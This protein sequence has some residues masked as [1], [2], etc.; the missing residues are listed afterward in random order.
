MQNTNIL[1]HR[2]GDHIFVMNENGEV[3]AWEIERD[4]HLNPVDAAEAVSS[5]ST[6]QRAEIARAQVMW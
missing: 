1:I 6:R 4:G 5:L 2:P 3:K